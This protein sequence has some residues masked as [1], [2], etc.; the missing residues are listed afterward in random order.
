MTVPVV[1]S[2]LVGAVVGGACM[3]FW[4]AERIQQ[5]AARQFDHGFERARWLHDLAAERD[6]YIPARAGSLTRI[7]TTP[8][9]GGAS[10]PRAAR[11]SRAASTARL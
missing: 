10:N 8:S 2:A 11:L 9:I 7:A 5:E 4:A 6:P 3:A 1:V